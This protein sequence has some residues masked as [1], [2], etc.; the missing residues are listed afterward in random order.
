MK[1]IPKKSILGS[2]LLL[3]TL[4]FVNL[5][6]GESYYPLDKNFSWTYN[7]TAKVSLGGGSMSINIVNF[8]SRNVNGKNVVPQ[9]IS[10][11]NNTEFS[12]VASDEIGVYEYATQKPS[13]IEPQIKLPSDYYYKLP[14]K[15][16]TSWDAIHKTSLLQERIKLTATKTIESVSEDVL[17]PAGSY[18]RCIHVKKTGST[19]KDMGIF[20]KP[21]INI[22][23]HDWYA[24]GVGLIKSIIKEKSNNLMIGFGEAS[25][26]LEKFEK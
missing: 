18:S 12:F 23:Q 22:E 16:G 9:K 10:S 21:Q 5:Y 7:M 17:V 3:H 4:F 25:L 14:L 20:G 13:D 2:I 11:G 6:A 8:A 19:T 1:S 15:V 24:P 26:Q